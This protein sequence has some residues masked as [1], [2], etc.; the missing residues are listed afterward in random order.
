MISQNFDL[1]PVL[2][3]E[4][5]KDLGAFSIDVSTDGGQTIRRITRAEFEREKVARDMFRLMKPIGRAS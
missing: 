1:Y 3:A 5:D 4:F 2:Q